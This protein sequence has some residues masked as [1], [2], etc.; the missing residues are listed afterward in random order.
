M[1]SQ[2]PYA[3]YLDSKIIG[4]ARQLV[5]FFEDGIFER[6]N[7]IVYLKRYKESAKVYVKIF[8]NA[9]IEYK[10]MKPSELDTLE[11]QTIFYAFNA[12]SNCRFVAN[13][14]LK[15]IFIT[16]GESNKVASIKPIIR[17]YDHVVMAGKLSLERYYKSGLFDEYDYETGRLIMMGDTFIGRTGFSTDS[18]KKNV[19]F[20]AP[21]WE[22]GL[23]SENYSSLANIDIVGNSIRIALKKFSLNSIVIQVHPNL[24]HRDKKYINYLFGLI[25]FLLKLDVCIS[26][27]VKHID[28]NIFQRMYLAFY[29]VNFSSL[30]HFYPKYAFVDIS[31][32]ESICVNE[33]INYNIFLHKHL[34]RTDLPT[35]F[36]DLYQDI[37]VYL[38]RREVCSQLINI[39]DNLDIKKD[40]IS[41]SIEG[42]SNVEKSTRVES[43]VNYIG[44]I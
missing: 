34:L 35:K 14:K 42:V 29:G 13:R 44:Q 32:M 23:E 31:A 28:F 25:R 43:L 16:H 30:S 9:G 20:Y 21:T 7:T 18:T 10:F 39:R 19:L 24:G 33:G 8:K 41:F 26:L 36:L 2:Y 37:G 15:H 3:L 27:N 12:Q 17:I 1:M 11:D 5:I 38:E 40:L 22:G 6:K 4:A